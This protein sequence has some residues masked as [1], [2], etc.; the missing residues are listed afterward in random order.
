MVRASWLLQYYLL[1]EGLMGFM[2]NGNGSAG[3]SLAKS[4]NQ[5]NRGGFKGSQKTG[6][7][8]D[9][10]QDQRTGRKIKAHV[11]LVDLTIHVLGFGGQRLIVTRRQKEKPA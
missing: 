11:I 2:R 7:G 9:T 4:G 3:V 10:G 6:Q 1:L 8:P 5:E